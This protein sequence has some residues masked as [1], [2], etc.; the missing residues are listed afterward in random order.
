M[1]KKAIKY[2]RENRPVFAY[3]AVRDQTPMGVANQGFAVK[4]CEESVPAGP[5]KL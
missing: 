5:A 4:D 3:R 2:A 1:H